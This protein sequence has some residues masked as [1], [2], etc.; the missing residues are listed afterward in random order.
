VDFSEPTLSNRFLEY[1]VV[2]YRVPPWVLDK[3]DRVAA[4][5]HSLDESS[6]RLASF[7][8]ITHKYVG[9]IIYKAKTKS[10]V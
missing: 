7:C 8:P 9:A 6:A 4:A 5:G 3:K 10:S 2:K 1:A